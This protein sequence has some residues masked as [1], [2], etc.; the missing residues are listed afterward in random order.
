MTAEAPASTPCSP[1]ELLAVLLARELKDGELAIVGAVSAIPQAACRLAQLSQAPRLTFIAGGSGAVNP[2]LE[3]LV[4]SSCD[5]ELLRASCRLPLPDVILLEGRGDMID[6]FFAGGLQI[7]AFGNCNLVAVGEWRR[8]RLRGPGSVGLTF[9]PRARR[10]ILYT[11]NH[12]SRTFVERV[13]FV[14]GPGWRNGSGGRPVLVATTLCLMDFDSKTRRAKVRSL[15][16]GV[17]LE[18]VRAATGFSLL[19]G[20]LPATQAPTAQELAVLRRIDS[21]GVLRS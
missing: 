18:Q 8:P 20:D 4:P 9:L 15:H 14:S 13:D 5:W 16:E 17:T 3:P 1:S 10:T 12:N 21:A 11:L 7:D 2:R 19:P 6:V